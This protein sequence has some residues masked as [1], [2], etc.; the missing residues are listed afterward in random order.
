M[1]RTMTG[2]RLT[3]CLA[4][5]LILAGG[6]ARADGNVDVA[7][8]QDPAPPA[9]APAASGAAPAPAPTLE[10]GDTAP[11]LAQ[12]L[13]AAQPQVVQGPLTPRPEPFYRKPWFWGGVAALFLVAAIVGTFT[14]GSSE[15]PTPQTTLGDMHAF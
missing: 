2:L 14:L 10:A 3:A 5:A 6:V 8:D 1:A 15:A 9:F 13:P 12:P 7:P 4:V 11:T